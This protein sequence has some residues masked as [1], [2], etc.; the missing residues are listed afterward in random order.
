[1]A[2]IFDDVIKDVENRKVAHDPYYFWEPWDCD[3]P[4]PEVYKK[5]MH[6]G[7]DLVNDLSIKLAGQYPRT[8]QTGSVL[9]KK[10]MVVA[11]AGSQCG[12]SITT[13]VVIGCM[14]SRRPPYSLRYE[15]G[16]DTGIK[17]V[18]SPLNIT[19]FGRRRTD[20][21]DLIDHDPEAK[22]N[23]S[24]DC[25]NIVG[26]GIF[27]EELY[28][29]EGKQIWIG[30]IAKSIDTFW[31]PAFAGTGA[32]RFFPKEF[33]DAS[34]GNKGTNWGTMT[35]HCINGIDV[36]LKT[37]EQGHTK[38]E[39]TKAWLLAYDEEPPNKQIYVSGAQHAQYQRFTFTPLNGVTWSKNVF[40]GCV[41]KGTSKATGLDR[42][43]F[44]YFYASQYDSPYVEKEALERNRRG[45]ELWQRKSRIWGQY[46]AYSGQPFFK[47]S[48][49]QMWA[50][51]FTHA[52]RL[53]RFDTERPYYGISGS[54]VMGLPGIMG[55][56]VSEHTVTDETTNKDEWRLYEN[57]RPGVGYMAIFDPAEGALDLEEVQDKSFGMIVREPLPGEIE[58]DH[59]PVIVAT[60]RSTLPTVA[61]AKSALPVMRYFNNALLASERG[62]GKDNEAFGMT[63]E[64]WPHWYI[65]KTMAKGSRG[66]KQKKGFD[67]NSKTRTSMLDLVRAWQDTFSADEDPFIKDMWL[68]K[69]MSEAIVKETNG[70][71]KKCD[72]TTNG[73]LD[74]VICMGIGCYIL[75]EMFE[76]GTKL[77]CHATPEDT[78]EH[79]GFLQR[80]GAGIMSAA[81][82]HQVRRPIPMG[83]SAETIG[84]R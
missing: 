74:G 6:D 15:E 11:Q 57:V 84:R 32:G 8:F 50:K 46:A 45:I 63:L 41:D 77:E 78:G 44:D 36:I 13:Q 59:R 37:Y 66:V 58:M 54:K 26:A 34:R 47:R 48:K 5:A 52:H 49:I 81:E 1:M 7:V 19:R 22:L 60:T 39:S 17:R 33:I 72:H 82:A 4:L 31:K 12:K 30:T 35:I 51:A 68:F 42:R 2:N 40:F 16:V 69:E 73:S 56:R 53:V 9:S 14:I 29:P 21:G 27:P 70:G 18:I 25:G 80:Q 38:F 76:A 61:F 23:D 67:T 10:K 20:T 43:D 75:H 55:V 62:H 64:E 3:V 28:C 71:K 65:Y 83:A 79:V 24:W